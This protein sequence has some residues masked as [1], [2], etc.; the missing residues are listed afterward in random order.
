MHIVRS[1][2]AHFC[3]S[4][5]ESGTIGK[6]L[7]FRKKEMGPLPYCQYAGQQYVNKKELG[8]YEHCSGC[9]DSGAS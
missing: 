3:G 6:L 8:E 9:D 2:Y 5:H 4:C 1:R 7:D